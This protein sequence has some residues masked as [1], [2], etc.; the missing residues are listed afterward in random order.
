MS[1]IIE[2]ATTLI[3]KYEGFRANAYLDSAGV[4]TIGYG[5][6]H[7]VVPRMTCTKTQAKSWLMEHISKDLDALTTWCESE[8]I[9]L[10]TDQ[11]AAILSFTYN[12]GF[13]AFLGSSIARDLKLGKYKDAAGH[14]TKW[15][16]IRVGE[17]LVTL[18]GLTKRRHEEKRLFLSYKF[19]LFFWLH[20][21]LVDF[22]HLGL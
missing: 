12:V 2:K 17:K 19:V 6:T 5:T 13:S 18:E 14:F 15:N 8:N 7:G 10:N 22:L 11:T 9:S 4:L 1:E 3:M 16:K 20:L 21:F